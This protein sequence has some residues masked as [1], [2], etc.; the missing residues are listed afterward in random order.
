MCFCKRKECGWNTTHNSRFHST[1]VQN[2]SSFTL[3]AIHEFCVNTGTAS[4]PSQK[5]EPAID[6]PN[7]DSSLTGY[8]RLTGDLAGIVTAN[9]DSTKA[10]LDHYNTMQRTMICPH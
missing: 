2:K 5:G 1:W 9:K 4:E 6:D 3:P 10:V 7:A 8:I